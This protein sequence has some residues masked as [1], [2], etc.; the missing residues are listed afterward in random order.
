MSSSRTGARA[1]ERRTET[2]LVELLSFQGWDY[3]RPPQGE[4]LQQGEYR[5]FPAIREALGEA[6]KSGKGPGYP[7]LILI[8]AGSDV[9]IAVFE[10]KPL[11]KE[12]PKAIN[13]AQGYGDAL[14]AAG[15]SPVAVA[16]AGTGDDR[17][18]IR[19][20]KRVGRSWREITY[21]GEPIGWIPNRDQLRIIR[22]KSALTELRPQVPSPEVLKTNAAEINGLL[23]EAG[24]KDDFR[25]AAIGAIML[26]L[27]HSR[28]DVRRDSKFIL[29]DINQACSRAFWNAG[30][31]DLARSLHVDEANEKLAFRARRIVEI[32]ERL[33]IT[34]LTAE[35]DYIGALYEEFFR[36]TG[37][38]TIGQYFTPRHITHLMAD[39]TDIGPKD[40][41]LD[42]ACGTGGFLIAALDRKQRKSKL[43]REAVIRTVKT[44][45]IGLED[46]PVTAALCVANMI[47]RGDGSS[48]VK[49]ADT[50]DDSTFPFD[51]A[52]V[53]LMNPPFPH[54]KTDTPIER[55]VSRAME[56]LARRGEA[57]VIIKTSL[58]TKRDCAPWRDSLL[59][60]NTLRAVIA[61][62]GELFQPYASTTTAIVIL[63][64]G[65]PHDASRST[66]FCRLENDGFRLKK[67]VRV[68]QNGSQ[69]PDL[70]DAYTKMLDIPGF[71]APGRLIENDWS[72]GAYIKARPLTTEQF[73]EGIAELIRTKAAF[74]ARF[75]PQLSS[76]LDLLSAKALTAKRY[77]TSTLIPKQ[78]V[79]ISDYF[80]IHYGQ[81]AL[82]SKEGLSPGRSLVISSS[83]DSNGA[84][85]FFDYDDLIAPPFVTVPSTGSIGEASVQEFACGVTDDCL[86]LVPKDGTPFEAL[87]VV[88]AVLRHERWRFDYGRKMTPSRIGTFP[89]DF[90][91]E[92]LSWVKTQW[93]VAHKLEAETLRLL[94]ART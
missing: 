53:V 44:Q 63:Q 23:R 50:F 41:I 37:G 61:L 40:V 38:N 89:I 84:Y 24:L 65:V 77:K 9:P 78:P 36:Y 12:L 75:A 47:L 1:S 87:F 43:S 85:G 80:D 4:T 39:L 6:S 31:P 20:M 19:V 32:L 45:L 16:V 49:R 48:G 3:R 10:A 56:G 68:P 21:G 88:A 54:R 35:H 17:F 72:P 5:D 94:G 33:N 29:A 22:G 76:M 71:C 42:P 64:K 2:L 34:V 51:T 59:R 62:P 55:F 52:N 83:G 30:K 74:A 58:L 73:R 82:H 15:F 14:V 13:E 79:T 27:W 67:G 28:G 66:F 46:E 8:D 18:E 81:K 69:I 90:D 25:P 92:L 7:E 57:A 26:G 91:E 93:S 86:I 11:A 70:L 60:E